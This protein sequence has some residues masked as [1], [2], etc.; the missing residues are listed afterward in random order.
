MPKASSVLCALLVFAYFIPAALAFSLYDLF[1]AIADRD[2]AEL[3][4]ILA[5]APS[6][7]TE[8]TSYPKD[9]GV[10]S[11]AEA[12]LYGWVP[13]AE[14]LLKYHAPLDKGVPSPL[15]IAARGG[16]LS[17]VEFLL[18]HGAAL[19]VKSAGSLTPLQAALWNGHKNLATLL[20]QRGADT[21]LFTDA[22]LGNVTV[23]ETAL[24]QDPSLVQKEG[25]N[26]GLLMHWASAGDSTAIADLLLSGKANL[27]SF[28]KLGQTA[29]ELAVHNHSQEMVHWL[30]D[31]GAD[32]KTGA[33]D[34]TPLEV[35]IR[36]GNLEAFNLL[37][38]K[39]ADVNRKGLDGGTPL[40]VAA[41]FNRLDI[42]KLLIAKGVKIDAKCDQHSHRVND[43][44]AW[45]LTYETPLHQAVHCNNI[46]IV[47]L[48]IENHADVNAKATAVGGVSTPLSIAKDRNLA[49]M[50]KYLE[51]HGAKP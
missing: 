8:S 16:H 5:A 9:G 32:F 45:E 50:A 2:A 4:K 51:E 21:D 33:N 28:G 19:N 48:L 38:D 49:E 47:K 12:A 41:F 22:A 35:S 46:D 11:M 23:V 31:H 10:G 36:A 15:A 14:I 34:E 25:P 26:G 37:L 20:L 27:N 13:G 1:S 3:E 42:A 6:L 40:H 18:A 30:L 44:Q 43:S 39:G 17:F 7:A 24:R 29:L